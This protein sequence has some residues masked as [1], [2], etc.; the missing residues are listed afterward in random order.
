MIAEGFRM[1]LFPESDPALIAAII[2]S[3]VNERQTDDPSR[4]PENVPRK[5]RSAFSRVRNKLT[6]F[7]KHMTHCGF[8]PSELHLAPA[9]TIYRWSTGTDWEKVVKEAG[10]EEGDL[11]NLVFRTADNLRH[12]ATLKHVFPNE[13][14]AAS[15]AVDMIMKEPLV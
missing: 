5:L 8:V 3:F 11:A 7:L 4:K 15:Q 14:M 2:A 13:A 6:P 1:G 9:I 12:I 10:I